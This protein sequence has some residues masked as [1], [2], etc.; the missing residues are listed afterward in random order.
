[1][2]KSAFPIRGKQVHLVATLFLL[3][4]A[5]CRTLETGTPPPTA[6]PTMVQTSTQTPLASVVPTPIPETIP[7]ETALPSA[8]PEQALLI[9]DTIACP[10][11]TCIWKLDQE[12]PE[13]VSFE[14][15]VET[16]YDYSPGTQRL[17]HGRFTARGGGPG[18]IAVTDLQFLDLISGA[19][20]QIIADENI[21]EAV[22]APNGHNLAYA[23]ATSTTYE[24]HWL[25]EFGEDRMLASNVAFTFSVSP[26]GDRVA[27]TR[28][29]NYNVSGQP[30]LYIVDIG[31][32]EEWSISEADRAGMGSIS[33]RPI[34]SPDG[35]QI[36]LPVTGESIPFRFLRAAVDGSSEAYLAISPSV[37][38]DMGRS[39]LGTNL[40]WH[41]D[42]R[43]LIGQVFPDLFSSEPRRVFSFELDPSLEQMVSAGLI[44]EGEGE[45]LGWAE[46][47]VSIWIRRQVNDL[48]LVPL[49]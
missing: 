11:L 8:T 5:G 25:T 34:W 49:Q 38:Q 33:D 3:V 39:S 13:L 7:I 36:L 37:A 48:I 21:G 19:G 45:L 2:K 29:S 14:D 4:L 12:P 40:F 10:E 6:I 24:L 9:S 15:K 1:M 16:V 28:E 32:G 23:K 17:L 27:F 42:N 26:A 46:P 18:N 20:R 41:P 43:H 22:W 30:G 47:G 35:S 44:Y 31:S